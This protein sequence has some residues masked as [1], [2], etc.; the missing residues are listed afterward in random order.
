MIWC[1]N[2]GI[3]SY[4]QVSFGL[5]MLQHMTVTMLG[6]ILLV[7]GAPA[8]LA[9]RALKPA[10]GNQRGAREWVTW[11][12]H[13]WIAGILTNPFYVFIVYVIGL[14]GLYMTPIFGWL[15]GSHIGH[16]IMQ[17]HFIAAGYLFYWVLIGIDPRPRPLPYWGR[18]LLLLIALGVHGFFAVILMMGSAPL[19]A[20]W[21]SVVRPTWVTDPLQDSLFGG[22]IAWGLSEIPSLLVMIVIG[23]QWS[24]SDDREA[25]RI[26]R[27][28]D[29]DGN[30]ELNAYN[31]RLAKLAERDQAR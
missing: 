4:A 22:Q 1:T 13:S 24:R 20:D 26:D 3:A 12:L 18:M 27:Q 6:P 28:A 17:V 29:R 7:L 16:I 21:Y 31:D 5:H 15:M 25:K 23:V 2:A 8:T 9:L 10:T 30:A 11:F 14:Y 19:A